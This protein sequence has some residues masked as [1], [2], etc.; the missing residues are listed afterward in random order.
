MSEE[1]DALESEL[2]RIRPRLLTPELTARIA[3]ALSL[4]PRRPRSDRLLWCAIGSGAIAACIIV[5]LLLGQ[6]GRRDRPTSVLASGPV[7]RAGDLSFAK[8][9]Q[10]DL[11]ASAWK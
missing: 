9:R 2:G 6:P 8:A 3:A 10:Q 7:P 4:P 5:L 11:L 1:L